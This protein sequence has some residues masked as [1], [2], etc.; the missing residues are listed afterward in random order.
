[1]NKFSIAAALTSLLFFT[2]S[3]ADELSL[4]QLSE[5]L[6]KMTT[7][8]S[9][10]HQIN[11]DGSQDT[12]DIYIQRPGRIR[13]EYDPPN[14][15]LVLAVS[16]TL[17]VFDPQGDGMP[18]N[19]PLDKTPLGLVLAKRVDLENARMVVGHHYDGTAASKPKRPDSPSCLYGPRRLALFRRLVCA[20]KAPGLSHHACA[21][22]G[23]LQCGV[24]RGSASGRSAGSQGRLASIWSPRSRPADGNPCSRDP[25]A[26]ARTAR[27][28]P[29]LLLA[30]NPALH[31]GI[32]SHHGRFRHR[33]PGTPKKRLVRFPIGREGEGHFLR[34]G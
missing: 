31:P 18:Q 12:G 21:S 6:N 29:E 11:A 17:S 26:R 24:L 1:M 9:S 2:P 20:F 10:F 34:L 33:A 13:F 15:A 25:C 23:L 4:A 8:Q 16:N 3:F 27:P 14:S 22:H 5:Y 32:P 28:I 30:W 7:A 19:Y